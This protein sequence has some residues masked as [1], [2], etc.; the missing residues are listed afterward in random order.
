MN[1]RLVCSFICL[2]LVLLTAASALAVPPAGV[3][4][5]ITIP[6]SCFASGLDRS[7]SWSDEDVGFV[8]LVNPSVG[9]Y[10][11]SGLASSWQGPLEAV[12]LTPSSGLA[13]GG[14]SF[15][16]SLNTA[17]VG[18]TTGFASTGGVFSDAMGFGLGLSGNGFSFSAQLP[19]AGMT[20]VLAGGAVLALGLGARAFF[21]RR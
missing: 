1:G 15:N 14:Y 12:L 5:T 4:A 6:G 13:E 9:F 19:E 7:L 11:T 2:T 18:E 16:G 8:S 10:A 3:P 21:R 17:F 20:A